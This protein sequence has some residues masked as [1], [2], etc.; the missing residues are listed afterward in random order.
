VF[1][2]RHGGFVGSELRYA[3]R[4]E[5]FAER[6]REVLASR[7]VATS[8]SRRGLASGWKALTPIPGRHSMSRPTST[9]PPVEPE[10]VVPEPVIPD[11]V[12][13]DP[14]LPPDP[15]PGPTPTPE[16]EPAG[17]GGPQEPGRPAPPI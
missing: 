10:P 14:D 5:A 16:P 9:A 15:F 8:T 3:G 7:W 13:P 12:T 2:R 1:P 4:P 17:P 11:P 6:L